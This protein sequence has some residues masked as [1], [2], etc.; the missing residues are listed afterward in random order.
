MHDEPTTNDE[1]SR[2]A[3]PR[4]PAPRGIALPARIMR[5][6]AIASWILWIGGFTF[7]GAFVI[8]AAHEVLGEH[9][10]VGFITR[11]VTEREHQ[12]LGCALVLSLAAFALGVGRRRRF[13]VASWGVSAAG[14]AALV[15]VHRELERF[16]D[17]A[18]LSISDRESFYLRH[19]V[20]LCI[21]TI[22]W[23]AAIVHA[24]RLF[25]SRPIGVR[26]SGVE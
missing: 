11:R 13:F 25:A 14:W 19:R 2:A 3:V 21:A 7:Y 6:A 10:T 4:D 23:A 17:P 5:V 12:C 20:Y 9:R 26:T 1:N 8:D 16:L 15:V 22:T 24:S 18:T